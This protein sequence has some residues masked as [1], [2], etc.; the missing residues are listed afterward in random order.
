MNKQILRQDFPVELQDV[1][2]LV[3][4]YLVFSLTL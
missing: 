1:S 4:I 3:T 2:C